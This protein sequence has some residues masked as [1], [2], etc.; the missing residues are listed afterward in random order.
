MSSEKFVGPSHGL[1][2]AECPACQKEKLIPTEPFCLDCLELLPPGLLESV[3]DNETLSES[4][5]PALEHLSKL[6][7]RS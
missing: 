2:S 1:R 7:S 3:T 4:F 5:G 6:L